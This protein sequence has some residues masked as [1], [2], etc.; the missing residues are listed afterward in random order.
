MSIVS[1][2]QVRAR[3]GVGIDTARYGHCASFLD[4]D[5]AIAAPMLRFTEDAAGYRKFGGQLQKLRQRHPQAIIAV[6]MDV[7]GQYASNLES[8]LH[9][10]GLDIVLSIGD[11]RQN[12]NYRSAFFPKEKSDPADSHAAARFAVN[13]RPKG[14]RPIS[15]ECRALRELVRRLHAVVRQQT[16]HLNQLH[17]LLAQ[18]FPELAALSKRVSARW[19]LNLLRRYPVPAKIAAASRQ[20]LEKIPYL[21]HDKIDAIVQAAKSSIASLK[22]EAADRLV[23]MIV[24]QIQAVQKERGRL[25][26]WIADAYHALPGDNHLTTI[27]GIGVATAAVLV[28]KIGAIERFERPEQLVSYFGVCPEKAESGVDRRGSPH[29]EKKRPMSQKGDDL[30]RFYLYNAAV[31]SIRCNP[32]CR[33]LY[34]RLKERGRPAKSALGHVMRKLVCLA[35]AVWK[36]NKPFDPAHGRWEETP[37]ANEKGVEGH[38]PDQSPNA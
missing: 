9:G 25:E 1:A 5:L 32:A 38:S 7:A 10:L 15:D 29:P 13:E 35:Y 31:A 11:P 8:F 4:Q 26:R 36:T 3:I 20:S 37:A 12:K 6:H 22:G 14:V 24:R 28:A 23:S 21:P 2:P 33:S 34:R 17:N 30:V 27:P 18:V 19:L 16:R